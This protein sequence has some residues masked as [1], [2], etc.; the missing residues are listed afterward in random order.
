[1]P[2]KS[3]NTSPTTRFH[4]PS[5]AQLSRA[6]SAS[7][8]AFDDVSRLFC[9]Q[10]VA[11]DAAVDHLSSGSVEETVTSLFLLTACWRLAILTEEKVNI[12]AGASL[13]SKLYLHTVAYV[14]S[15][16]HEQT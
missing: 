11:V 1:M 4:F 13:S 10:C 9:P 3:R 7:S 5:N 14:S 2:D 16:V 8:R 6:R 15:G 12:Q